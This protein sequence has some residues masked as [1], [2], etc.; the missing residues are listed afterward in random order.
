MVHTNEIITSYPCAQVNISSAEGNVGVTDDS[1][2]CLLRNPESSMAQVSE[3]PDGEKN[4]RLISPPGLGKK[5]TQQGS[6]NG[7]SALSTQGELLSA[8]YRP[9]G[10]IYL[11]P[12]DTGEAFIC[13][14]PTQ[15]RH[16][17]APYRPRGGIYLH[18]PDTGEAFICTPRPK[19]SLYLHP[20]DPGE[21]FIC[22]CCKSYQTSRQ[23]AGS[24][25]PDWANPGLS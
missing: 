2:S 17:S 9:R 5:N 13:T 12:P 15:G 3:V 24:S 25:K 18:P 7:P 10:G 8:P 23:A 19:A 21:E 22:T 16:L 11:H 4:K 14:L 1:H 20:P 6:R